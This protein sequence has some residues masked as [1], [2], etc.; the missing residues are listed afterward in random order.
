MSSNST[1]PGAVHS[2]RKCFSAHKPSYQEWDIFKIIDD[3]R[4]HNH[5]KNPSISGS[6]HL[7]QKPQ[8]LGKKANYMSVFTPP[9]SCWENLGK[10]NPSSTKTFRLEAKNQQIIN[11]HNLKSDLGY[12]Q[13]E[14]IFEREGGNTAFIPLNHLLHCS[15]WTHS[16]V[17]FKALSFPALKLIIYFH[18]NYIYTLKYFLL[19][20]R[21]SLH[22]I[23]MTHPAD[24]LCCT[25]SYSYPQQTRYP[26][27]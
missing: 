16:T 15:T 18:S 21:V 14:L 12:F 25:S 8:L 24:R 9:N 23:L 6:S 1:Q 27:Y 10:K 20:Q 11:S 4:G 17:L 22:V 26:W 5:R 2:L 13:D 7:P 19:S 3:A